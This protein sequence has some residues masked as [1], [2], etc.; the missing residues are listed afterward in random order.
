MNASTANLNVALVVGA[1]GALGTAFVNA[2]KQSGKFARVLG[3]SRKAEA[4]HA[5]ILMDV[6]NPHQIAS[7][8]EQI[9]QQLQ[10]ERLVLHTVIIAI[11]ILHAPGIRPE[12]K[13]DE[14]DPVAFHKVMAVN[15]LGPLLIAK[16]V[17]KLLPRNAPSRLAFLSAR[18]GSVADNRLGG[19]Y[20]YRCSKSALNM[21]IKTLSIEARRTHPG[22]VMTL[23]QPGTVDSPL[24]RPFQ[25]GQKPESLKTAKQSAGEILQV[26]DQRNDPAAHLFVDWAGQEIP[27]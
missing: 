27:Y 21:G 14:L 17:L 6:T 11:G 26:L 19:W 1:T 24:S 3:T 12:R 23:M 5:H 22:C 4:G 9:E 16:A 18:V 20:S 2:L 8:C 10:A 7:A 15:A 25:A 13:L